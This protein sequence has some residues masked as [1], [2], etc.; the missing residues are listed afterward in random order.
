M[1]QKPLSADEDRLTRLIAGVGE[2]FPTPDSARLAAVED[3]LLR[4]LPHRERVRRVPGWYWW[5]LGALAAG[6]AAAWWAGEFLLAEPASETPAQ[7]APARADESTRDAGASA[8][9][10]TD[11]A[12]DE[13]RSGSVA[14]EGPTI[15]RRERY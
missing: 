9:I 13:S 1:T 5:L 11:R 7:H 12:G 10:P 8:P 4:A 14:K 3:R 6:G 15:I 2:T